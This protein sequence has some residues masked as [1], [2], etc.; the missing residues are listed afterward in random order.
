MIRQGSSYETQTETQTAGQLPELAEMRLYTTRQY[1]EGLQTMKSK[2][3]ILVYAYRAA[4]V[5]RWHTMS[6]LIHEDTVGHHSHGVAMIVLI[7]HP[8]PSAQLLKAALVHDLGEKYTGDMSHWTK[9][10]RP[11]LAETLEE[12]ENKVLQERYLDYHPA[13][14]EDQ[15]WLKAADALHAWMVLRENVLCGNLGMAG[16]YERLSHQI[17]DKVRAGDWPKEIDEALRSMMMRDIWMD[18]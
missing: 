4:R 6:Y 11:D 5:K 1:E 17:L 12:L 14:E 18:T 3:E 8:D 15:H 10:E 2:A 16:V 7:L 9:K 13:Y